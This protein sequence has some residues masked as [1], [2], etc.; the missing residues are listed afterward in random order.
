MRRKNIPLNALR[1]FEAAAR[2][3]RQTSAADELGVTHGAVSRQVRQLED[4]LGVP[5]FDGPRNNPVLSVT[6]T[7]LAPTLTTAFDQIDAAIR[8]VLNEEQGVLDIACLSSFAMRLLIPRLHRFYYI[9]PGID[10]RLSTNDRNVEHLQGRLDI[11]ILV[12]DDQTRPMAEDH[13]LFAEKLGVVIA[14]SLATAR[15]ITTPED[16]DLVA[17]LTTITRANAWPFLEAVMGRSANE[18]QAYNITEYEHYTFAIEAALGGLGACAVP[19]HLV[20]GD[21]ASGRL[22]APFGFIETGYRYVARRHRRQN[23]TAIQF[24]AWLK[25]ELA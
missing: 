19:L 15:Q 16:L 6:G 12:L 5:L 2:C 9:H 4:F 17:R 21:L 14:P 23:K 13:L 7:A 24:C 10:V 25:A 3:G 8:A 1:A 18:T 22:I 11:S 20:S